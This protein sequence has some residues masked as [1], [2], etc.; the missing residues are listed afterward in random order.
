MD[1]LKLCHAHILEQE[2]TLTS[3]DLVAKYDRSRGL[4]EYGGDGDSADCTGKPWGRGTP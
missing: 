3:L 2:V 1:D 4:H